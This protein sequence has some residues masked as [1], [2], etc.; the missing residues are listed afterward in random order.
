MTQSVRVSFF[1]DIALIAPAFTEPD[2]TTAKYFILQF[3]HLTV[4]NFYFLQL[5]KKSMKMNYVN[6]LFKL[7]F[8]YTKD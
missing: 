6:Y 7:Q 1:E 3:G 2:Q 4:F 5:I 8:Q